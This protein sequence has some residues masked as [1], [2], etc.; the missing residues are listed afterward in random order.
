MRYLRVL[1]LSMVALIGVQSGLVAEAQQDSSRKSQIDPRLNALH[2]QRPR[3][4]DHRWH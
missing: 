1:L 2:R 3:Q 4:H